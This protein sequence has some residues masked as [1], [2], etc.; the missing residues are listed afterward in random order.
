[1][2]RGKGGARTASSARGAQQTSPGG[3]GSRRSSPPAGNWLFKGS[4][5]RLTAYACTPHGLLRWTEAAAPHTGWTGPDLF[6]IPGWMGTVSMAQS[7]EGYVHF[8]AL[9]AAQ[10]GS[11]RPEIIVSTQFQPG[12]GMI[13]WHGLGTPGLRGGPADDRLAGPPRIAVNQRSGSTHVL[14]SMRRGGLLRRSRNAEGAWG[15][16]KQV[17]PEPYESGVTPLMP[18]GGQLE[19]LVLGPAGADRWAGIGQGRFA[20]AHRIP[21]AV[22]PG[23]PAV[24]ETGPRRVTYFWRYPGDGSLVAWRAGEQG[25]QGGLMGLGGAGGR[26]APG[27]VRADLG[28]YDCTVLAQTGAEGDIEVTAYVTENEGYGTWWASLGGQGAYAPQVAVDGSGRIA[29]AAFDAD[30]SLICTRQDT[31]QQGLVFGPWE[32]A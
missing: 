1:M 5:G 30:G 18:A 7:R 17:G 19:M 2:I 12:R 15:G 11:G 26:G 28:G 32:A 3:P 4:D 16:W 9:R 23:T 27:V 22:V 14:V 8:V 21:T 6:E 31:T 24:C 25:V 20:L 29:V 10:D 13:D